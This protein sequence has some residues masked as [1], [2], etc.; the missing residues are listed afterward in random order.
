MRTPAYLLRILAA[1][2]GRIEAGRQLSA[3]AATLAPHWREGDRRGYLRELELRA[4]PSRPPVAT[5]PKERIDPEAA[6]AWFAAR[7]V[8]VVK[9]N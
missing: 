3:V 1:E 5:M 8:R 4:A 7:G 2:A 9:A 6:A